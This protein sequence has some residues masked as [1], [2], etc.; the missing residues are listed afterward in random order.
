ME[1]DKQPISNVQWI[2]V[3]LLTA[4]DYNPNVVLNEEMKLLRFSIIKNGWIQPILITK[5]HVVID[6][7][8]RSTLGKMYPD[9]TVDGKVPCV[10]MD[11]SE[12]ERMLLTIRINRAK[13]SHMA[14]KMSEI[15]HTLVHTY[16]LPIKQ[17]CEGIGATKK[18]VDL[19]LMDNVFQAKGIT[20]ETEY[21]RAWESEKTWQAKQKAKASTTK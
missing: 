20:E 5:E 2:D 7:F 15:I 6:G 9:I 19:L 10:I 16:G 1:Q 11:M 3:N 17:I 12:P 4:N 8:H 14:L 18:E 21:S 13:G